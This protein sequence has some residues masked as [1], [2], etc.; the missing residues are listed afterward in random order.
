V[1]QL[2]ATA[3]FA[4]A[5]VLI[6]T[7]K[8]NRV[9]VA[10]TGAGLMLLLQLVGA[11]DVFHSRQF[12]ID[13][14]V[15]F[16]LFG[17]MVIVGALRRTGVFEYLAVLCAKRF[18]R[19]PF[20]ILVAVVVITAVAS[21]LLD[22]VTTVLLVVPAT[23]LIA[24]RLGLNP[25]PLL[26]AEAMASNIGGTATLIGDPPNIIIG[27]HAGLTYPDFLVHLA[28]L[29]VVLLLVFIG[30]CWLLFGR[31][32][33]T[34][35]TQLASLMALDERQAIAD[36]RLLTQTLIVLAGVTATFALHGVLHYDASVIAL[37]GAGALLLIRRRDATSFLKEVE[38]PTLAFFLG[39]FVMVGALV[40]TGVV[41]K[42]AEVAVQST[43]GHLGSTTVVLL[44]GSAFLSAI[45]DN[46]PYVATMTPLVGD[47]ISTL[48]GDPHLQVLWW[49]LALGADLG[50]NATL[51]GASANVVT[52][53]MAERSGY[54]ITFIE[55]AKYG[56]IVTGTTLL[57][58]TGYVW[59]RYLAFG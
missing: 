14:N 49:A 53:G 24:E 7:E 10:L 58:S 55:F 46:I 8:V 43:G 52:L 56:V 42:L 50:G 1:S 15:L 16:L 32:L 27:T 59:L 29:V 2:L 39:L 22:N 20:M 19:R 33:R 57:V 9:I 28:P 34:S 36:R 51:I 41:G 4:V 47:V 17:M 44:W 5:Y 31:S 11:D 25:V 37:L 54:R 40:K 35:E 13:W 18:H 21:A 6:A 3:I 12:G 48:G 26:I 45:V 30:L 38:W 23:I